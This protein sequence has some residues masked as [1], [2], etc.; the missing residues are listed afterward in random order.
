QFYIGMF[1][2]LAS[3]FL[4]AWL[5]YRKKRGTLADKPGITGTFE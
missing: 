2:I 5:K 3:V 4:D 1:I